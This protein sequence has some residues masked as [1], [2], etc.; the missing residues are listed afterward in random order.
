VKK[1]LT[2]YTYLI[3]KTSIADGLT[4]MDQKIL[5]YMI[6]DKYESYEYLVEDIEKPPI[7]I[8]NI[9]PSTDFEKLSKTQSIS[10]QDARRLEWKHERENVQGQLLCL[11]IHSPGYCKE[12]PTYSASTQRTDDRAV[13]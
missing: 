12:N 13:Y 1:W 3:T 2:D 6:I 4:T 11:V 9:D 7:R 8:S 5:E 10:L